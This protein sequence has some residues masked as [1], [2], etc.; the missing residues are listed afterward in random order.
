MAGLGLSQ[1]AQKSR[2]KAAWW[3]RC[4]S[5]AWAFGA[6]QPIG[7]HEDAKDHEHDDEDVLDFHG[8]PLLNVRGLKKR[9]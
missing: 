5:L 8:L 7:Q 3:G 1:R 9:W 6:V 2:L 4:G